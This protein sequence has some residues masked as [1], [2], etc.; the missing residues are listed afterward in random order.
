MPTVG[1]IQEDA[2]DR[3]LEGRYPP[4][5]QEPPVIPC[6]YCHRTFPASDELFIHLGLDHPLDIPVM[7][8]QS[9]PVLTEFA[10]RAV[11]DAA[12]F[13]LLNSTSC[14][15]RKDGGAPRKVSLSRLPA[16]LAA[17][18]S[19]T[20]EL[21]LVNERALDHNTATVRFVARFRIPTDA[22]LNT[23]DKEFVRLLA[24]E[25]PRLADVDT[26]RRVCPDEDAAQDY[27]GALGDYVIGLAIK[28]RH[29]DAGVHLEFEHYKEKFTSALAVLK[30]FRRP[31][32]RAI[33]ATVNFNLNNFTVTPVS[34]RLPALNT[35]FGFFRAVA[36]GKE[37][38]SQ[39][40]EQAPR[41]T[42]V[43]PVDIVTHRILDA[44]ERLTSERKPHPI[45][46]A[47]LDELARWEPLSEYD[48]TKIRVLSAIA[49][50]RLGETEKTQQQLRSLQFNFLFGKWAQAGLEI[51]LPHGNTAAQ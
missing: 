32:A 11:L 17:E 34:S 35:A 25:H 12:D 47:G 40:A 13:A 33:S 14:E 48:S 22:A 50:A 28:E 30:D 44:A 41:L 46:A 43:C 19:S 39:P 4:E 45:I 38:P 31:V 16:L 3:F 10:V 9:Q 29:P 36:A 7:Q 20:C 5:Q 2:N 1:W 24:V 37:P 49:H 21:R 27:A 18:R 26:F 42:S 8:V 51:P 6:P 23:I 15:L